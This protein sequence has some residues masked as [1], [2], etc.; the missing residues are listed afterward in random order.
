MARTTER[1]GSRP[2]ALVVHAHPSTESFNHHLAETTAEALA[3]S[4]ATDVIDLYRS[5]FRPEMTLAEYRSYHGPSPVVDPIVADHI[6]R[7]LGAETLAFVYPTWWSGL[8]AML[9]GWLEKTL[10]PGVAF[11][12]DD[13]GKVTPALTNVRRL[14]GVT[15]YGSPR[16]KMNLVGDGGKRTVLRAVRMNVPHRVESIW[17]GIHSLDTS[18]PQQRLDFVRRVDDRL[19]SL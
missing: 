8:P 1:D 19:R 2:R 9:K 4:H 16:W 18:T 6:E 14:I 17:L 10:V 11:E 15:S 7:L 5:G 3:T 13:R 12:F